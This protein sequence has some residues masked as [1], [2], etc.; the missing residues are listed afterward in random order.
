MGNSRVSYTE[1]TNG[2]AQ[3]VEEN[4]Y[5]AF[6]LQHKGY[7]PAPTGLGNAHAEKYKYNG[8][9]LNEELGINWYDYGARN[10]DAA[11]GRWMNVDPLAEVSRRW[12]PYS[13][14]YDNPVRFVDPD[15]MRVNYGE[16]INNA[17]EPDYDWDS[18]TYRSGSVEAALAN[19]RHK[20]LPPDDITVN[21]KG[22]VTNVAKNDKPDR[23]FDENGKQLYFNDPVNDFSMINEWGVGDQLYHPISTTVL[24]TYITKGGLSPL[25]Y[26]STMNPVGA[27]GVT[28]FLS[29]GPADF[30][31]YLRNDYMT[32]GEDGHTSE[33]SFTQFFRFGNSQ[34]I[35]NLYDAGNFMW[36]AWMHLN[37]FSGFSSRAGAHVNNFLS[38]ILSFG[39]RGGGMLD[40]NEDQRAITNGYN[41]IRN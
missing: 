25:V 3:V 40:S 18:G 13:Y 12:S 26:K 21:S 36:G 15:G 8:K 2:N 22:I 30:S 9:E 6:G 19:I 41:Y 39:R 10:Y 35:Y 14:C 7:I 32:N 11:I 1:G 23:F 27:L 16:F 34:S 28:A 33:D 4:S 17:G 5:Y 37:D 38:T 24:F 31:G 20:T 29:W